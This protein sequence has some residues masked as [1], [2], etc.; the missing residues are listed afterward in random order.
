MFDGLKQAEKEKIIS[1]FSSPKRFKKGE[2]IYCAEC[3]ENAIGFVVNGKAVAVCDNDSGL[4][5][6][7]FES[8]A[9]FGAAAVFGGNGKYI[10]TI[11]A[12]TDIEVLFI[13]E[14]ELHKMFLL[15]PETALNYINFLSEKV[16]FLNKKL[17]LLSC[18]SAEDTVLKYLSSS[19]DKDGYAQPPKSMTL[20]SKMLGL[21]RASLYR[22]FDN[23]EAQGIIVREN[24]RIKVIKNEKNS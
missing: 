10:S 8:G 18:T 23:L 6:K 2:V 15:F 20:L 19:A 4:H 11:I 7:S 21:G 24:N 13:T 3:F 17:S 16:R 9:C 1:G 14:S 22:S 5:M 12:D